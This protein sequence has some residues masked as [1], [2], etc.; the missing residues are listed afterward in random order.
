[1]VDLVYKVGRTGFNQDSLVG[2]V[3]VK[4]LGHRFVVEDCGDPV[5]HVAYCLTQTEVAGKL[6][7]PGKPDIVEADIIGGG[8]LYAEDKLLVLEGSSRFY[9]AIPEEAARRF[10]ELLLPEVGKLI[11][12]ELEGVRTKPTGDINPYW[13]RRGFSRRERYGEG[14]SVI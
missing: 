12:A 10:G 8:T 2:K 1:M 6:R 14:L 7:K 11:K 5:I 4:V 3:R 13:T 9:K